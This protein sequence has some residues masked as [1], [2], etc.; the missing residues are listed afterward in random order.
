MIT[1]FKMSK[2]FEFDDFCLKLL[3]VAVGM[4]RGSLIRAREM[5]S[6]RQA[7]PAAEKLVPSKIRFGYDWTGGGPG[8][9]RPSQGGNSHY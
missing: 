8:A 2:Y 1:L 4:S 9:P 5:E 7:T 6:S 3:A